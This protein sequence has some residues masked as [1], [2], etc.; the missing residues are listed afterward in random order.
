VESLE[1]PV[2]D[3]VLHAMAQAYPDPV[4]LGLLSMVLGC[5]LPEL[6][7]ATSE[8]VKAG[9]AHGKVVFD[10]AEPNLQTPVI[11]DRGMAVADGLASDGTQ[12]AAL[13]A[14]LEADA[15]RQLLAG[16]IRASRL[17]AQQADELGESLCAIGDTTL[18]EAGQMLAHQTVSD[19]RAFVQAMA[20]HHPSDAP[21]ARHK[22]DGAP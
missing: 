7:A 4:D 13:L 11:T 6:K 19:W 9:L 15:L 3:R 14:K 22:G 21:I 18:V 2:G 5:E 17:P 16:R 8:L 12:A 10:G 20:P 1:K